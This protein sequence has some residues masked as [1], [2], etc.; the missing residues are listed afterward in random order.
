MHWTYGLRKWS[1]HTLRGKHCYAV[2][3]MI[4]CVHSATRRTLSGSIGYYPN[5]WRNA[6]WRWPQRRLGCCGLVA[7]TRAESVGSPCLCFEFYGNKDRQGVPRVQRRT[8]RKKLQAACRRI[9]EWIRTNRHLPGREFFER[10]NVRLQ[11]HYN[12]YGVRG[13][14]Q[15]LAHFYEWAVACAFKWLNRRS[16]RRSYTWAQFKR[17]L[18]LINIMVPG[19]TEVRRQRV[20][21]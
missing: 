11:G 17:V 13:N 16:Q 19:I 6:S 18:D 1:N 15:A 21:A 5:A 2:L 4:G 9:K 14:S 10:L 20:F 7:F 3:L 8:A 12:S